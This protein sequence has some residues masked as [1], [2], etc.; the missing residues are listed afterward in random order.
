MRKIFE[1]QLKIDRVD[2]SDIQLDLGSRDEIPQLLI[3]IQAIYNDKDTRRQVFNILSDIIPKEVDSTV[4][5]PG[6]DMWQIFVL[7]TLRLNCN[8]D[9][10]KVM[11]I[12][13]EHNTVRQ[14]LGHDRYDF[15]QRYALQT[16]KD[17]VRL[18]SPQ[19]LDKINQVVVKAGHRWLG[20]QKDDSLRGRC[21]SFVVQTDVHYPTDI[22]LLW[23]ALRKMIELV[24][25]MCD[26][27][28]ISQWRQSRYI[29]RQIKKLFNKANGQK[30]GRFV[31]KDKNAR[32]QAKRLAAYGNYVQTAE[33]YVA[34]VAETLSICQQMGVGSV[35]HVMVIE[36]FIGQARR[37]IDQIRRRVFANETIP[38]GE[39]VFSLFEPHTEWI[40]KG[41]AGVPQELG[42]KVCVLEDQYGFILH[43][44]VMEHQS[45]EQI[46]VAMVK[47]AQ[48]RFANLRS[49]SFD[50]GFHSPTNQQ[51]LGKVLDTVILPRKGRLTQQ[52]MDIEQAVLFV[53]GRRQHAA[54]ESAINALENHGLD[55]CPDHGLQGFKRYVSLAVVARNL[56]ILGAKLQA[57][58][59]KQQ[60]R[61]QAAQQRLR[62]AA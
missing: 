1:R 45:D 8:F 27:A 9:Y 29:L 10:D 41:K 16:I 42:L 46:G 25:H 57:K 30:N 5:R 53:A 37:Q 49:C 26:Q 22:N 33:Q 2:I 59:R 47:Q 17:N 19:V 36:Q 54:V 58:A 48:Q 61:L 6:M 7:G 13:N 28:G 38:H 51:Q 32:H 40:S 3:G 18:L 35:A 50:K 43:H 12:A 39:K 15:D 23:D 52:A 20:C 62:N 14:F 11:E 34:R 44:R 60:K 21:D 24:A 56:Q 4:G 55:R 31:S